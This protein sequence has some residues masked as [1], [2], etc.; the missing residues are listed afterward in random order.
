MIQ[1]IKNLFESGKGVTLSTIH[2]AKG[3]EAEK[4]YILALDLM[5]HPIALKSGKD[6][7]LEQEKNMK[8]VAITRSKFELVYI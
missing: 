2:K 8:Y 1:H 7:V 3:L 5:P 4:V 6:W